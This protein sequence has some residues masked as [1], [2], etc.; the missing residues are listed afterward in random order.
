[1][2]QLAEDVGHYREREPEGHDAH[3]TTDGY[4][5][6]IAALQALRGVALVVAAGVVAEIGDMRRFDNPRQFMAF[7]GLIPG[8]HSSGSKRKLTGITKAGSVVARRLIVESSWAYRLPAKVGQAM[9]LR[10]QSIAVSIRGIAW[11]AQ[12]RLCWRYP[13]MLARGKK[14]PIVITAV[15]R[16]LVGFM[17]AIARQVKPKT[18]GA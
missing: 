3:Q 8:E 9:M 4:R 17:W 1:M 16:E 11:K 7:I 15:A 18:I 14:A 12:V 2:P 6:R 13:R 10:H 5:G